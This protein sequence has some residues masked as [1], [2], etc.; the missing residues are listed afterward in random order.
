MEIVLKIRP[1]N[2]GNNR[3]ELY[4]SITNGILPVIT[5]L[6]LLWIQRCW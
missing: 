5:A 1:V 3:K 2:C 4:F 6:F